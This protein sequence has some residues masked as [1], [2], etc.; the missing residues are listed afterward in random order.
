MCVCTALQPSQSGPAPAP[1]QMRLVV[2]VAVVAEGEVVHRPLAGRGRAERAEQ[3]GRHR[4]RRLHVAGR[5][6][7]RPHRGE[8]AARR[9]DDVEG[10]EAA[11]VER[12]VGV[13]QRAEDVE[14]GRRRH[15][16][17]RVEV[18]AALRRGAG[19]VDGGAA[20]R[21]VDGHG[22]DDRAAVVELLAEAPRR[23][24][25]AGEAVEHA[26][27]G[28]RGVVLHV[29]HVGGD[30]GEAELG[31]HAPQLGR[32]ARVGRHLGAQVGEVLLQVADGVGGA[33]VSSSA[34][35][36]SRS[37]PPSTRRKSSMRT[38]SSSMVRL[39]GGIE[40][41]VTPPTSAWWAREATKKRGCG[42]AGASPPR[43]L[44][45]RNTGVTTV[46]S[47]RCVPPA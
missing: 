32:A 44:P 36:A 13:D 42:G 19:E 23:V 21:A 30:H 12:D 41:G 24:R 39:P 34:T 14:H 17:G 28:L 1:P 5:H 2:L 38:P 22:D 3:R 4:L 16:R 8:H 37:R 47:G 11:G 26:A 43:R 10:L 45:P 25:R 9:D 18:V 31:D 33:D 29:L 15:R 6:G 20:G 35:S 40:P 27:H 46:R 7:G